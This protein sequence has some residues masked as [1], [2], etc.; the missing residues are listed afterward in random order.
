MR[1]GELSRSSGVSVSMIKY[2]LREGLLPAGERAGAPNQAEYGAA[3]VRRLRLLRALTEEGELP[4]TAIKQVLAAVDEHRPLPEAL[5]IAQDAVVAAP[6]LED[7]DRPAETFVA[8][9][10]AR[11]GWRIDPDN[12]GYRSATRILTTA[13]RLGFTALAGLL[14]TYADAAYTIAAAEITAFIGVGP[15]SGDGLETASAADTGHRHPGRPREV[16]REQDLESAV[17]GIVLGEKMLSALR[18]MAH[19]HITLQRLKP[20]PAGPASGDSA[21]PP[22]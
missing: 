16:S 19:Q 10:V 8:G 17:T 13:H 20:L 7:D 4:A 22:P 9:F 14:D 2:Y 15:G 1:V 5:G 21:A 3:H 6:D 18:T 11:R 12:P